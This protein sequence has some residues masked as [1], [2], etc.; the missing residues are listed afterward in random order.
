MNKRIVVL[1]S[2]ALLLAFVVQNSAAFAVRSPVPPPTR[3]RPT[4]H[5]T[6]PPPLKPVVPSPTHDGS[7]GGRV[8]EGAEPQP[9]YFTFRLGDFDSGWDDIWDDIMRWL[10]SH[11]W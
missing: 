6:D 3:I 4:P 8:H 9:H 2:A 7:V 1:L 11:G 5:V 10:E